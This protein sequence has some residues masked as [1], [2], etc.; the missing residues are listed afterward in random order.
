MATEGK[1][2]GG[3]LRET[4]EAKGLQLDDVTRVTRIGKHHLMAIE[5]DDF[6]KL[7]NPA[8][9]RGFIK[10]Y[11][12]FLGLPGEELA[13]R[14]DSLL[15]AETAPAPQKKKERPVTATLKTGMSKKWVLPLIL[16]VIAAI[17]AYIVGRGKEVP[18]PQPQESPAVQQPVTSVKPVLPAVTAPPV[19]PPRTSA[20]V[21]APA[22]PAPAVPAKP[23]ASALPAPM[24]STP[25]APAPPRKG[26]FLRLI[27]SEETWLNITIDGSISK[28]Y[29]LKPGDVI[30]WKGE[31]S[32]SL[33]IGNAGGVTA[34]FNG[35]RLK[36]FGARGE[37]AHVVLKANESP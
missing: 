35:R 24:P 33:D 9:G 14:Y 26:V 31:K 17:T 32:F 16:F 34:V 28:Q 13:Q 23:P 36:P 7:P 18:E 21:P 20:S 22:P 25:A 30:E 3:I 5:Q 1:S 6:G 11:A 15:A 10:A 2:I 19:Q 29:Q 4:R 27:V 37:T 8:Y 12:Q